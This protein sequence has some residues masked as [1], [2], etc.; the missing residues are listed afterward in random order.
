MGTFTKIAI[1]ALAS[2]FLVSTAMAADLMAPPPPEAAMM[3][4][5]DWTGGYIGLG[6]AGRNFGSFNEGEVNIAAG[7]WLQ[8]EQFLVGIDGSLGY[9]RDTFG[10]SGWVANL[11]GR[12]GIAVGD[13]VAVYGGLGVAHYQAGNNYVTYGLGVEFKLADN[14]SLDVEARHWVQN[15]GPLVGNELKGTVKYHF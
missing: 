14:W 4:S 10:G 5:A 15:G 1:G 9:F 3:S 6:V 7:G 12:A 2:T 11:E 8:A 13:S